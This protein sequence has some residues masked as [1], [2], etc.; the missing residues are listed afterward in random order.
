MNPR[1][2]APKSKKTKKNPEEKQ[3]FFPNTHEALIDE[4]T[5]DLAQKRI[6][7]KH[8]P[9]KINEIDLFSGLLFCGDCGYKM[10]LQQGAGTPERKHAYTCGKYRNRIR[11]GE[12]C[13]THYI[14]KSVLKELVLADLQRV[15][16]YVKTHE[17][18]FIRHANEY[19][20]KSMQKAL[21]RQKKELEKATVR[22]N[23]LNILFRKLYEDNALG[24]LSDEQFVFLTSGY[25][26]EKET[27]TRRI[28]ELSQEID[29]VTERSVDVRKFVAIVR[30][31]T[32]IQELTYE[33]V[34][35]FIDRILIHELD[36]ETNTR[37]IEIMY[38]FVGR[39]ETGDQPTESISYFRQ[40][41]ANVK[42]YA[43]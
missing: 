17:K 27:L 40:I 18:E 7:T 35:E 9:N 12:I 31:Y 5:F 41:G 39:V 15:L 43:I 29:K 2:G 6:A 36:K 22:M 3:Y 34:H 20:A 14:R 30:K 21:S 19:N 24:K 25:D 37:K 28:A 32:A 23:E 8:R 13:T 33:N 38:S 4:E 11:T 10:Y 26:E 16:S 42:S 1:Q